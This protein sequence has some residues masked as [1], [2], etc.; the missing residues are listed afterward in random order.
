MYDTIV[1]EAEAMGGTNLANHIFGETFF[2]SEPDFNGNIYYEKPDGNPLVVNFIGEI[3]SPTQDTHSHGCIS[4]ESSSSVEAREWCLIHFDV[5]SFLQPYNDAN[6]K[7][8]H[9]RWYSVYVVPPM[10]HRSFVGCSRT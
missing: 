3:G 9:T 1:E 4:K 5:R 2:R 6:S 8:N 7:S 10:H